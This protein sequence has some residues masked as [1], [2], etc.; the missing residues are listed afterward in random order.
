[1]KELKGTL[2]LL[3]AAFI[4]GMSFVAQ[5]TA[6]GVVEPFTYNGIRLLIGGLFLTVFLCIRKGVNKTPILVKTTPVGT[7]ISSP[8]PCA[9]TEAAATP[10]PQ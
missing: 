1:M 6:S 4:W 2:I 9:R 7:V 5:S 8:L 10:L 3:L